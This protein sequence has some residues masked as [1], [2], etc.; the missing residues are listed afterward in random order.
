MCRENDTAR[1]LSMK[2]LAMS[3]VVTS[4]MIAF[5]FPAAQAEFFDIEKDW[6]LFGNLNQNDVP[7]IGPV[8]CGPAAAV[9]S[10]VY[11]ENQYGGIYDNSLTPV[12]NSDLDGDSDVD[13]YDDMIAA[14]MSLASPTYMNTQQPSGTW[15]DYFIWGKHQYIETM[16]PNMTIYEAQDYW[17]WTNFSRPDWVDPVLPTWNFIYSE[18]AACE[19]VEIL[20]TGDDWGHFLTL[21]GYQWDDVLGLGVMSFIDPWTGNANWCDIWLDQGRLETNYNGATSFVSMAVS[22]SPVPEPSTLLLLVGAGL[23]SVVYFRK[24][25]I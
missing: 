19:D 2:K 10:F 13:A 18:L 3:I 8:A 16:V 11:L 20:L 4:C 25:R 5:A 14:A 15:H 1:R 6:T 24:R 9:N 21:Y 22:E 12:Q 7:G 17:N 23:V